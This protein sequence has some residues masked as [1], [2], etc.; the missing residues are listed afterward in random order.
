MATPNPPKFTFA[1]WK[2]KKNPDFTSAYSPINQE[3]QFFWVSL[4]SDKEN[5]WMAPNEEQLEAII[6]FESNVLWLKN[7]NELSLDIFQYEK[8]QFFCKYGSD[9]YSYYMLNSDQPHPRK[10]KVIKIPSHSGAKSRNFTAAS[11]GSLGAIYD[12]IAL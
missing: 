3:E 10:R 2:H 7:I 5:E 6:W 9:G 11:I 4:Q 8:Y 12:K 1:S